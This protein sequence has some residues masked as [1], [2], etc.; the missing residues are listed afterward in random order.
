MKKDKIYIYKKPKRWWKPL[1]KIDASNVT[2]KWRHGADWNWLFE[3]R[4][5]TCLRHPGKGR[6]GNRLEVWSKNPSE[7]GV[8]P[9]FKHSSAQTYRHNFEV[10]IV[11]QVKQTKKELVKFATKLEE[12]CQ[13]QKYKIGD[14]I[15]FT[16]EMADALKKEYGEIHNGDWNSWI[17][18]KGTVCAKR[19]DRKGLI[20]L[21]FPF[22]NV[23]NI[24]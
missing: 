23:P 10:W 3:R 18:R 14:V 21:N 9:V 7:R 12:T 5:E 1:S 19:F 6:I 4:N 17:G 15:E 24:C 20:F 16:E 8:Y 2:L 11:K 13:E 22:R